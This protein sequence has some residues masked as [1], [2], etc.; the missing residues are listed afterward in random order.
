MQSYLR[1][2]TGGRVLMDKN[3]LFKFKTSIISDSGNRYS[4][5]VC[6]TTSCNAKITVKNGSVIYN[7]SI[8]NHVDD[9]YEIEALRCFQRIRKR[10][11]E[12]M[13]TPIP[14][15]YK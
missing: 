3:F 14:T 4:W 2:T 7:S 13:M 15:I 11:L 5:W 8:H 12:D 1:T 10:T 9:R 6:K